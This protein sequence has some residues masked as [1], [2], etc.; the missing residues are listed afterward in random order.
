MAISAALIR[1]YAER[2]TDIIQSL[3][4]LPGNDNRAD[5][6]RA[7]EALEAFATTP[8]RREIIGRFLALHDDLAQLPESV[9]KRIRHASVKRLRRMA[10]K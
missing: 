10:G 1:S 4:G 5:F 9:G 8:E 7:T 6:Y 2:A 3:D